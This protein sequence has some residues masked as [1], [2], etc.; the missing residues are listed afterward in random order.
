MVLRSDRRRRRSR[1]PRRRPRAVGCAIW[2]LVA[3]VIVLLLS[4]IF[5]GFQ[6]GT[7][8]GS[9]SLTRERLQ[10]AAQE[11]ALSRV[12]GAGDRGRVSVGR[13]VVSVQAVQ[14]VSPDGV[15]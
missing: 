12:A 11:I 1:E 15:E 4:L 6:K 8:T 5:G 3:V 13:R 7:K 2:L 14:E 10:P 9:G